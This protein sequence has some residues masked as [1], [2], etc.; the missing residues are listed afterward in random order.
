MTQLRP[1]RCRRRTRRRLSCWRA[2]LKGPDL[3]P[4]GHSVQYPTHF[5]HSCMHRPRTPLGGPPF[6]GFYRNTFVHV[7]DVDFSDV[8]RFCFF[9]KIPAVVFSGRLFRRSD[10]G[11]DSRR[12]RVSAKTELFTRTRKAELSIL[13]LFKN[14]R[15]D[16]SC[17]NADPARTPPPNPPPLHRWTGVCTKKTSQNWT[18][19]ATPHHLFPPSPLLCLTSE[20][21]TKN[22]PPLPSPPPLQNSPPQRY[23]S[24]RRRIQQA[25]ALARVEPPCRNRLDLPG[26]HNVGARG[27]EV[28]VWRDRPAV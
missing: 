22:T 28:A 14:N 19:P 6:S 10:G 20:A 13:R 16:G 4:E 25:A 2:G 11:S 5:T 21:S 1:R 9:L 3:L 18:E 7:D 12:P 27:V 8:S 17:C 15:F 24:W 23:I 26:E